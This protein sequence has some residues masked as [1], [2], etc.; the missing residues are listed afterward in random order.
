MKFKP[1][2]KAIAFLITTTISGYIMYL[3]ID[4]IMTGAFF[5]AGSDIFP[6]LLLI[7]VPIVLAIVWSIVY[8]HFLW[9]FAIVNNVVCMFVGAAGGETSNYLTVLACAAMVIVPYILCLIIILT[10][11]KETDKPWVSHVFVDPHDGKI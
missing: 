3:L 10:A 2:F 11:K 1:M 4:S 5:M 7:L 8:N 6:G 9:I